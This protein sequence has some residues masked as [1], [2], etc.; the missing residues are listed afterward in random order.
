MSKQ[1]FSIAIEASNL[2]H[3]NQSGLIL[4][5]PNF[6]PTNGCYVVVSKLNAFS[7]IKR[8]IIEDGNHYLQ[9]LLAGLNLFP[10]THDF[11]IVGVIID[12][13]PDYLT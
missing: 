3:F 6:E 5:E 11:K 4:V 8:Y 7:S 1:A 2:T 10:L 9:P 13:H 12:Y